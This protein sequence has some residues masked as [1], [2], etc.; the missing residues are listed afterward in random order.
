LQ[1]AVYLDDCL[2]SGNTALYDLKPWLPKAISG[3]TLYLIFLAAHT[4]GL[5]YLKRQLNSEAQN[6]GISVDYRQWYKFHNLSWNTQRFDCLWS[7]QIS[8]DDLVDTYIQK[9]VER[10][11]G[12]NYSPRLFRPSGV[13]TQETIFSSPTARQVVERA[14][15]KAGAYI[16]SLPSAPKIEMRPLGYEK[17]ESLGFGAISVTYRNIANNCPLALWWGDPKASPNHPFT[18]WYPLFP[19]RVNAPSSS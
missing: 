13:P 9:V 1:S 16:V 17:L 10:C 5:D 11:Q 15:L 7:R 3:T 2:F 12:K 14:F 19:R 4:S 8:G 18:K 6:H